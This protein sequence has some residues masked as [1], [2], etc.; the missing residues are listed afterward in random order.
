MPAAWVAL[1][2]T[3]RNIYGHDYGYAE[4]RG[5]ISTVYSVAS[6]GKGLLYP[7]EHRCEITFTRA[8][9]AQKEMWAR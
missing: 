6:M 5:L 8:Y 7:E 4:G 3:C 2:P 9:S 1:T